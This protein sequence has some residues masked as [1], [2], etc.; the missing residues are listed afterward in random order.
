[1]KE[2]LVIILSE[3]RTHELTYDNF[4]ANVLDYLD[5]DLCV[6]IGVRD[7]YDYN[8][9]YYANATYKFTYD[10]PNDYATAFDYAYDCISKNNGN[11][12]YDIHWREFLKIKDQFMGGILDNDNQHQGS[13]GLLIFFRWFLLENFKKHNLIDKYKRFII[14]RSD[15]I[16]LL[17]HIKMEILDDDYI[18]IPDGEKYKGVT[19]RHIILSGKYIEKFLN[20]LPT[21]FFK[22]KEY[23]EKMKDN[24]EWNIEQ[25]IKFHLTEQGLFDKVK[26]IP[27]TMFAVRNEG[28]TT[29][30][31]KGIY[32]QQLGCYV[33]YQ[34]ELAIAVENQ[35]N[36]LNSPD[37]DLNNFYL[38]LIS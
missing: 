30:W 23:F 14:T 18:Y 19:D 31:A 15:F 26:F 3:T 29:R 1:M 22:G 28:G 13:G 37:K 2:T 35:T 7:N 36:F 34:T 21:F 16:Y 9:P 10:E 32:N 27:Y 12:D 17:P 11:C 25:L 8:N 38:K 6:C 24:N 20:I 5:A 4:K 33:K